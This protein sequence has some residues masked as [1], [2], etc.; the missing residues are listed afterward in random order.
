MRKLVKAVHKIYSGRMGEGGFTL[1]E[2][3]VVIGI[4]AV[5]AGVV[6]L[7]VGK[8]IG[9]GSTQAH[10]T[11]QHNVQAAIVAYMRNDPNGAPPSSGNLAALTPYLVNTPLCSYTWDTSSGTIL[12]QTSCAH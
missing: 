7:A 1:I 11:D 4:L 2:L 5:L 10:L 12:T 3:L 8:F 9:A 6:T